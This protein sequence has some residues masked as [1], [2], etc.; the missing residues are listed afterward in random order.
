MTEA[1]WLDCCTNPAGMLDCL[2]GKTS[3]RKLRLFAVACCRSVFP[4]LVKLRRE[5]EE[6]IAIAEKFAD[7]LATEAEL[8]GIY[9]DN[10]PWDY[11]DSAAIQACNPEANWAARNSTRES[12]MVALKAWV[13]SHPQ[14]RRRSKEARGGKQAESATQTA[15]LRCIFGN[16]FRS[17]PSLDPAWLIWN[18]GVVE[19]VAERIYDE[20]G[21]D[22]LSIL[23][24]AL[25]EAGCTDADIL[26]H[27]R[28]PGE[29]VRGC[30]VVDLLLGK[31]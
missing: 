20:R 21:F 12:S 4:L 19:K 9:R 30:W 2:R 22:H 26:N 11:E 7:G 8:S 25:E 10:I 27:C 23:A 6:A 1:E 18:G 31:S 5:I 17:P 24:D 28:Q 29:H 3:D 13:R 15:L 16:P 14:Y